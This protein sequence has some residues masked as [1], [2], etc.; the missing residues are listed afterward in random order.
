MLYTRGKAQVFTEASFRAADGKAGSGYSIWFDG[1]SV[2][3]GFVDGPKFNS[4]EE[5]EA[6][7]IL[8]TLKESSSQGFNK[9][10]LTFVR[11]L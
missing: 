4:S 9:T 6:R 8:D 3:A 1:Y 7:A 11:H 5:A 10:Q 2:Q